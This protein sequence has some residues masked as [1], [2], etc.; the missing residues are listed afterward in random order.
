MSPALADPAAMAARQP[1]ARTFS[2]ARLGELILNPW[3]HRGL[4][5]H[6]S[7]RNLRIQYKQSILGYAWI[8]VNPAIQLLT[9]TFVFSVVLRAPSEGVPFSLFL[10]VGLVPW[11]FFASG[12]LQ[13]TESVTGAVSLVTMVYFPRE[14]LVASTVLIRV[15]DLVAGLVILA[16]LLAWHGHALTATAA[17]VPVLL[18]FHLLFT[19][20][21]GLPL[22][23]LNLFFH[24][25]RFL[26]GVGLNLWFLLTPVMYPVE[27]VPAG[28]RSLYTLNPN[29]WFVEAYR[30][31]LLHGE[32]PSAETLL[33]C[34]GTAVVTLI[35]GYYFFKRVE[36]AFADRI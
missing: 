35:G 32:A 13:A 34:A 9:F 19:L 26:V 36:T 27:I 16:G 18:I 29:T 10:C 17:W 15:I 24:D 1:L 20:G 22:A 28:Y 12:V 25:V 30:G 2:V 6:L 7:L 31:A 5:W 14:I 33:W 3:R 4:L 23:S 8:L 11:L 21:L